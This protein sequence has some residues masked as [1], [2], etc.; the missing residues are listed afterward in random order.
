MHLGRVEVSFDLGEM[1]EACKIALGR[2]KAHEAIAEIIRDAV[3]EPEATLVSLG[4]SE[5]AGIEKLYVSDALTIINVVWAPKMTLPAHNHNTW[6]VIGV[7]AGR[8]DNIFWRKQK[9]DEKGEIKAAGAKSIASGEV[10][11]LGKNLI[12]SVTNPTDIF[13]RAIHVYG[14]NFFEIERSEW[15]PMSLVEGPYNVEKTLSLFEAENTIIE[16]LRINCDR[17]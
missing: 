13:T 15:D 7:Y 3:C 4:S 10:A 17:A 6:A 16:A 5:K 8:E 11:V 9:N 1:V 12:H 14:G 2:D